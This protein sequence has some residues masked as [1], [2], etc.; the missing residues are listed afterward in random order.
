VGRV[1]TAPRAERAEPVRL[2][3]DGPPSDLAAQIRVHDFGHAYGVCYVASIGET[4]YV[5]HCFQEE[6][7]QTATSDIDL[8]KR[9]K[10]MEEPGPGEAD[11]VITKRYD[12]DTE[13]NA[14]AQAPYRCW[15]RDGH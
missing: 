2:E 11:T 10:Q 8:G 12:S 3:A 9:Y 15:Q 6:S 14:R 5:L 4:V 7:P 1:S 13:T